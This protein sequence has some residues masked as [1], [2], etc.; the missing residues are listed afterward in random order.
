TMKIKYTIL[1][2]MFLISQVLNCQTEFSEPSLLFQ[3]EDLS[4]SFL[5]M[6][7][8]DDIL[9]D[10]VVAVRWGSNQ[11]VIWKKNMGGGE[12]SE[13]KLISN[14]IF[15]PQYIRNGDINN[16]GA[17]DLLVM[18]ISGDF[19]FFLNNNNE[20]FEE[21][22][23]Y[24]FESSRIG[25]LYDIDLDG[26]L[27]LVYHAYGVDEIGYL[28]NNG[29]GIFSDHF[30]VIDNLN[31]VSGISF[32][33]YDED[34]DM[35]IVAIS[36][37]PD[38]IALFTNEGQHTYSSPHFLDFSGLA[39]QSIAIADMNN[40]ELVDF[41]VTTSGS[42]EIS[43]YL[44][45]EEHT[46]APQMKVINFDSADRIHLADIDNDQN[47]DILIG[48]SY[49]TAA[50]FYNLGNMNFSTPDYSISLPPNFDNQWSNNY[51]AWALIAVDIDGDCDL[52]VI[53]QEEKLVLFMNNLD[54]MIDQDGDGYYCMDDC[55]D[56][57]PNINPGAIEIPNNEI[58]ENCDG[59]NLISS[60]HE[61]KRFQIKIYPN[62]VSSE[63]TI[64]LFDSLQFEVSLYNSMGESLLKSIN[65]YNISVASI[66]SGSYFLEVKDLISG[67]F[68]TEKIIVI[69]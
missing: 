60:T 52:D 61:I 30:V 18:G 35:D 29:S 6:H 10:L 57:N 37:S 67:Q 21:P 38:Q 8:D 26:D 22:M 63:I 1:L 59:I 19:Y 12:F 48:Q 58:D 55:D 54:P 13:E 24:E 40:D 25:Q 5:M 49:G 56:N 9:I 27:D 28:T 42:S 14:S 7:V 43:I 31:K 64:E 41:V 20:S 69:K 47:V 50:A 66:P 36:N 51:G 4:Q 44:N 23:L 46:F 45:N 17:D 11:R 53:T 2:K 65:K 34:L 33:D 62:P 32:L 16:D 39:L 15:Q 3:P 68:I